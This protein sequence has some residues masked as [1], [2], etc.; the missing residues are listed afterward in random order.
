MMVGQPQSKLRSAPYSVAPS[1]LEAG[2]E[3]IY[4]NSCDCGMTVC[5]WPG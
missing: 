4:G 1:E 2:W 5:V 3:P